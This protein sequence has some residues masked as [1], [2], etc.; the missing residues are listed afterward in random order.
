MPCASGRHAR[1][2]V[3]RYDS[4]GFHRVADARN[5]FQSWC[6]HE[7]M[8]SQLLETDGALRIY[9]AVLVHGRETEA[10]FACLRPGCSLFFN[11]LAETHH[12]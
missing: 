10:P 8:E 2:E 4:G 12:A 9:R 11:E 1:I 5:T 7:F 3:V 6:Q